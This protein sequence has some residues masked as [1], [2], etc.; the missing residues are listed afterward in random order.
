MVVI[1]RRINGVDADSVDTEL[2]EIRNVSVASIG[3]GQATVGRPR[4]GQVEQRGQHVRV[5]ECRGL[6]KLAIDG[7]RRQFSSLLVGDSLLAIVSNLFR[8]SRMRATARRALQR[9][10]E[11]TEEL[12]R[13]ENKTE[14]T[15]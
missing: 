1:S 11:C 3:L 15:P 4:S 12:E 9:A 5:D 7:L 14:N 8:V 2:L 6:W 10:F 13:D